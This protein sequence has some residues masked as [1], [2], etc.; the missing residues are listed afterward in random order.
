MIFMVFIMKMHE[1]EGGKGEFEREGEGLC[2]G[3]KG[4]GGDGRGLGLMGSGRQGQAQPL[5]Y[6]GGD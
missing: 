4:F 2:C 1:K 5:Q 6:G 3:W